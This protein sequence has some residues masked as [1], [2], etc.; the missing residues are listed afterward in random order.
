MRDP[1]AGTSANLSWRLIHEASPLAI[2]AI[3][4]AAAVLLLAGTFAAAPSRAASPD[5]AAPRLLIVSLHPPETEAEPDYSG[6]LVE[7]LAGHHSSAVTR[8]TADEYTAGGLAVADRLIVVGGDPS[9]ELSRAFIADAA[10]FEVPTLWLGYGL[11]QLPTDLDSAFGFGVGFATTENPPTTV[12]YRGRIYEALPR[13]YHLVDV[14]SEVPQVLASYRREGQEGEPFLIHSGNLWYVNSVPDINSDAPSTSTDAPVLI[15]ADALHDFVGVTH[16]EGP[17]AV[18]RLEDI[19]AHIDPQTL[20]ATVEFL[21]SEGVP[22]VM[23]V[24]PSQRLADGRL[25]ALRDHPELVAVLKWAQAHGGTLALHGYHH[26]FGSGE[27]YEF[28]D[29]TLGGP[30]AGE[31]W[32]QHAEKVE[33]GIRI[34]RD[35]GLDPVLWETPH[36]AASPLAYEVFD[37]YFSHAIENRSPVSWLPYSSGPDES[38]HV[39]IPETIGY[40]EPGASESSGRSVPDMLDRARLLKI[41]RDPWAVGFFHP[42]EVPLDQLRR[43]VAGIRDLGYGFEDVRRLGP[44]VDFDYQPSWTSDAANLL[45]VDRHL[46]VDEVA[47]WVG[48]HIPFWDVLQSLPWPTLALLAFVTLFLVRLRVQW[49][50]VGPNES[51]TLDRAVSLQSTNTNRAARYLGSVAVALLLVALTLGW[52]TTR[53]NTDLAAPRPLDAVRDPALDLP[54]AALVESFDP[55][56]RMVQTT[57]WEISVYFTVLEEHFSGPLVELAGCRSLECSAGSEAL[58]T[59]PHSFVEA[60]AAEG[61][62]RIADPTM[63]GGWG[64]LNWSS[65]TGYWLDHHARDARGMVLRPY[66]TVAAPAGMRFGTEI[67]IVACGEDLTTGGV[68]DSSSCTRLQEALWRV[69]D[70]FEAVESG[71]RIDLYIGEADG[72]D[73]ATVSPAVIHVRSAVVGVGTRGG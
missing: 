12:D 67:R 72:P 36:Y 17:R 51:T 13:V 14:T 7:M 54:G 31:T 35:L 8:I 50:P 40:V 63:H 25:L 61:T 60:V 70:R 1:G 6:R 68:I 5:D 44:S 65:S 47:S 9:V 41:V 27:D 2:A 23:A 30:L 49:A 69:G 71:H 34:L 22:F 45:G 20:R 59:F 4:T 29:E 55:P 39:L 26:T 57:D 19:S 52:T 32:E 62:G 42:V 48:N 56:L 58:G 10:A 37:H 3:K 64:Y 43:L 28:W 16:V 73:F 33:D 46:I 15:L 11:D 18:I 24:I 53:P 38:G 66:E 21:A